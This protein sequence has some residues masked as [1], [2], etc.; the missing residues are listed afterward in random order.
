M[1]SNVLRASSRAGPQGPVSKTRHIS[2]TVFLMPSDFNAS[3][4]EWE[5]SCIKELTLAFPYNSDEDPFEKEDENLQYKGSIFPHLRANRNF[6]TATKN[7]KI[8]LQK[9]TVKRIYI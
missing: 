9:A 7:L 1:S 6:R 2:S 5:V 4:W 8:R 3:S